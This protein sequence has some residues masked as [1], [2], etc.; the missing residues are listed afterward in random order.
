MASE[1]TVQT[2]RGPTSGTN[3]NKVL[4]PSGQT[5]DTSAA[6]LVTPAGHVL[7][8][9]ST[10]TSN[11]QNGGYFLTTTA[12]TWPASTFA[13]SITPTST[14]SKI[15]VQVTVGQYFTVGPAAI[16]IFRGSTNL[17]GANF[18]FG[19]LYQSALNWRPM[20]MQ[21]LDSPN[22]TSEVTY[23]VHGRIDSGTL[24]LSGDGDQQNTFTL[25]EI[26]G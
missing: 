20:T 2:L 6:G 8:V 7:Q 4:I 23:T 12:D 24:Y 3:A 5:L 13:L 1:L 18:G 11:T 26:A 25:M 10:S 21:Y 15:Y 14:T 19:Q 9:V 22:T 16:S 17:G